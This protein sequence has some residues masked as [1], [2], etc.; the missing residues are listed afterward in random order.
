MTVSVLVSGQ[1]NSDFSID[2]VAIAKINPILLKHGMQQN[3]KKKAVEIDF[4]NG[5]TLSYLFKLPEQEITQE[6][7]FISMVRQKKIY[8]SI[9]ILLDENLEVISIIGDEIKLDNIYLGAL[10]QVSKIN[11]SPDIKYILQTQIISDEQSDIEYIDQQTNNIGVPVGNTYMVIPVG[12]K[13]V[14]RKFGLANTPKTQIHAPFNKSK[15]P[16]LRTTGI[17]MG[18]GVDFGGEKVALNTNG[19]DYRAGGGAAFVLGYSQILN[20]SRFSLRGGIGYKYQ[21][22]QEG[23]ASNQGGFMEAI[24]VWQTKN[25]NLGI[26]G[27]YDFSNKIKTEEGDI[28]P[29]EN[30]FGPKFLL[31]YKWQMLTFGAEYILMDFNHK[32]TQYHANRFGFSIKFFSGSL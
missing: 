10:G 25:I 13:Q 27:Q 17:Y 11:I 6:F 14:T 30:E 31:E 23:D 5:P 8:P 12:T 18:V 7:Q 4:G 1:E 24:I 32:S 29:F 21:G 19:D 28:I 2:K 22:N 20:H 16:I 3:I 15:K 9:Y 26:G